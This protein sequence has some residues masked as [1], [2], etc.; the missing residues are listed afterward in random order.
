MRAALLRNMGDDALEV[1]DDI[2]LVG[3]GA[4]EQPVLARMRATQR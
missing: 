3:V 2:E 4:G 1:R